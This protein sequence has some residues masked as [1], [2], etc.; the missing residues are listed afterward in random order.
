[1]DIGPETFTLETYDKKKFTF[2]VKITEISPFLLNA[3]ENAKAN[4]D[5]DKEGDILI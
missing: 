3:Y 2:P 1:M 4:Q 5:E